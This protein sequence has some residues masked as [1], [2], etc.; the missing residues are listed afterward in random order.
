MVLQHFYAIMSHRGVKLALYRYSNAHLAESKGGQSR[1]INIYLIYWSGHMY[2]KWEVR[3]WPIK[4]R[5]HANSDEIWRGSP[6]TRLFYS[7]FPLFNWLQL[8]DQLGWRPWGTSE[9]TSAAPLQSGVL[10]VRES[11]SS[12]QKNRFPWQDAHA[13]TQNK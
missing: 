11:K 13:C 9:Q 7:F 3:R 4:S 5:A 1:F 8:W 6:S 12:I 10:Q 2:G